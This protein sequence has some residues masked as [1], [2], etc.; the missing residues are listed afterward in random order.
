MNKVSCIECTITLD[1]N[2]HGR[3]FIDPNF[4][5]YFN[6]YTYAF[7]SQFRLSKIDINKFTKNFS[8]IVDDNGGLGIYHDIFIKNDRGDL[9]KLF[10]LITL[11]YVKDQLSINGY[12][13]E[14]SSFQINDNVY[15][16]TQRVIDAACDWFHRVYPDYGVNLIKTEVIMSN[17]SILAENL[18][19]L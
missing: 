14:D 7:G 19:G 5:H 8:L 10:R 9:F 17:V 12:F 3:M 18:S 13:F 4:V 2:E 15:C 6:S 16:D 1:G 11:E